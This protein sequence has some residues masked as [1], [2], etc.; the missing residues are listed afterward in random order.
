V[1]VARSVLVRYTRELE[2][3]IDPKMREHIAEGIRR[4]EEYIKGGEE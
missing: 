4:V 3:C 2:R 1:V